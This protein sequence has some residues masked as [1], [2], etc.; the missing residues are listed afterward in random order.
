M[1]YDGRVLKK[2]E[3]VSEKT[4]RADQEARERLEHADMGLFD[5]FMKKLLSSGE[6]S[7]QSLTA[8]NRLS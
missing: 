7:R 4:E 1:R 6:P 5:R 2:R 3:K 8:R